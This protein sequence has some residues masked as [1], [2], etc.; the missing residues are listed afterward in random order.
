MP[1]GK[2]TGRSER[3][4]DTSRH[5]GRA[6]DSGA[7]RPSVS[8]VKRTHNA[9]DTLGAYALNVEGARA[10]PWSS[11]VVMGDTRPR[12]L[13]PCRPGIADEQGIRLLERP[14]GWAKGHSRGS[15]P[16]PSREWSWPALGGRARLRGSRRAF[17][18]RPPRGPYGTRRCRAGAAWAW[19]L[20]VGGCDRSRERAAAGRELLPHVQ[21][22]VYA[23]NCCRVRRS[24]HS[25]R[26]PRAALRPG[27][28][29]LRPSRAGGT[30][31]GSARRPP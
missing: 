23:P 18:S 27:R 25:Q 5:G 14:P 28:R 19:G 8:P 10:L 1:R 7:A 13:L 31:G 30:K 4:G 9:N 20:R 24:S 29:L 21:L 2:R 26:C 16:L 11:S 15:D 12:R 3:V 6:C 17:R 22:R